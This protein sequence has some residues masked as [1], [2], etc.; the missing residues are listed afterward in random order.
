MV[1]PKAPPAGFLASGVKTMAEM[2]VYMEALSENKRRA[3][4]ALK[5]D[6][7]LHAISTASLMQGMS[8]EQ[9]NEM[10]KQLMQEN[11]SKPGTK[12]EGSIHQSLKVNGPVLSENSPTQGTA[13][14]VTPTPGAS[15]SS[16]PA[17][18]RVKDVS[19]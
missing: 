7:A 5:K 2:P 9:K 13:S 11:T 18:T 19:K 3:S 4:E 10:L 1:M 17:K 12:S 6:P 15:S 16:A 8:D 14:P